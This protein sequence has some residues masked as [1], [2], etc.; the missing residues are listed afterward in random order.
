MADYKLNIRD[1]Y[2]RAK[3]AD[4]LRNVNA[5]V[6]SFSLGN[7]GMPSFGEDEL[8]YAEMATL[9]ARKINN[10][11]VPFLGLDFNVDGTVSYPGSDA[12]KITFRCDANGNFRN[13]LE[14]VQRQIFND[15]TSTGNYWTSNEDAYI[16]ITL[17]SK[18]G[19]PLVTYR[20]VGASLKEIGAMEFK[21]AE[22]KGEIVT[23]ETT[24]SYHFYEIDAIGAVT[25]LFGLKF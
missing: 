15:Q 24:W 17:F 11:P 19:D 2:A 13:K 6:T 21:F 1:F 22:G 10:V 8:V 7:K 18:A 25:N 16:G 12:Y 3:E 9:P 4:F 5:R 20:L 14:W 23:V